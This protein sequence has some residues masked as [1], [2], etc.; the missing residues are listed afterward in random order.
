MQMV[1]FNA[2][3]KN[4]TKVKVIRSKPHQLLA[5]RVLTILIFNNHFKL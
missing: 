3:I 5:A 2:A 4:K 1:I